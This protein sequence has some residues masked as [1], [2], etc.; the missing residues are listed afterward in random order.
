MGKSGHTCAFVKN[1]GNKT[2]KLVEAW[3]ARAQ[4]SLK[5]QELLT[6]PN[7]QKK[8][9]DYMYIPTCYMYIHP[10][11][12]TLS[13][14]LTMYLMQTLKISNDFST[15]CTDRT[16]QRSTTEGLAQVSCWA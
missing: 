6:K 1:V 8:G 5:Q 4:P 15:F 12:L 9:N 13:I 2:R 3:Q 16:P 10:I 14:H 11:F 7:Y